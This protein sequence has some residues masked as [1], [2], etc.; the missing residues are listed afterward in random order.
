MSPR[1]GRFINDYYVEGALSGIVVRS[2]VE[3]AEILSLSYHSLPRGVTLITAD[4]I[5]GENLLGVGSASMPLL[6]DKRV[7]YR[8]EP[9]LLLCG[10]DEGEL[11]L[12]AST[13]EIRFDSA[14]PLSFLHPEQEQ[15]VLSKEVVVGE[16]Q[17]QMSQAFQVV[18]GEYSTAAQE[19]FVSDAQGAVAIPEEEDRLRIYVPTQWP[20]HVVRTV[21]RA[22]GLPERS[23]TVHIPHMSAHKDSRIWYPSL[24]A[25]HAA[26]LARASGK[27][28]KLILP[29]DDAIRTTPRRAPS[30]I[31]VRTAL[32]K[33]G[34]PT[35]H[36]VQVSFDGGSYPLLA[37]EILERG[38]L[39]AAGPYRSAH[40]RIRGQVVATSLPPTGAF[41]GLGLAQGFFA[42]ETHASRIA[43]LSQADPFTWK[44][45]NLITRGDLL[46]GFA[47]PS[48]LPPET[49]LSRVAEISD[50]K[51]KHAAY[52][53]LKK[54]RE[55]IEER[56]YPL[57]GIG[58]SVAY[59]GSD[60]L[61]HYEEADNSSVIVRLDADGRLT[62]RTSAVSIDG[63]AEGVWKETAGKTLGIETER[64]EVLPPDTS[65]SPDSG[66]S[67]FSRNVTVVNT[68]IARACQTIARKRFRAALP[69]EVKRSFAP[70]RLGR[71]SLDLGGGE[72][73]ASLSWGA[74]V[75]ETEVDAITFESQVRGIWMTVACGR[76]YDDAAARKTIEN[77]IFHG[78][79]WC[80]SNHGSSREPRVYTLPPITIDFLDAAG[81]PTPG[82]I[83]ELAGNVI[84]SAYVSAVAQATGRYF[85][86]L[87]ITPELIYHYTED[88]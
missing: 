41:I 77:G 70:A 68:L 23:I 60:F 43:E 33:D 82:G 27:S 21:A 75:V 81:R 5:P 64:I 26:L 48:D 39:A 87:P 8:G 53:M 62:V 28:V 69:I 35:A 66:P 19:H 57:R 4:E 67:T 12:F 16:P 58:I 38:M 49:L 79:W 71:F 78:L 84:P 86:T 36:D 14:P 20:F 7:R 72:P 9:I 83:E 32:D 88:M 37:A 31:L 45:A 34:V 13:I 29:K 63:A 74:A 25:A 51:R 73:F 11:E 17:A 30:R 56:G 1:D 6:A 76:I 10:P 54:R 18:E 65:Q 46:A 15:I 52:E 42:A 85:D 24:V 61:E 59:Q 40:V 44:Q 50:F 55:T 22:V 47:T 2:S 80:A 3:N